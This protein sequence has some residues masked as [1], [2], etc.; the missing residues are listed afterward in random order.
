MLELDQQD[1]KIL[2][3]LQEDASR[4]SG[5]IAEKLNISQSPC[6][7][8]IN[9]LH[10]AGLIKKTVSL[11]NREAIGMDLVAFTTINLSQAGRNNMER[12]EE[13]VAK[14]D[15]VVECYTMTGAWDYM[16]KVVVK[17]IRHYEIF[18]RNQLLVEVPN[19]GEIHSHM[20]VTEIKNVT[21]LPL[22]N[23]L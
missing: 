7:R 17:D 13:A 14:L 9:R 8:R 11:L 2:E 4:S 20:A 21:Q 19:I 3:L 10:E 5:E 22:R 15:E 18:V 1:I 23:Q 16:L 6:W 12:F